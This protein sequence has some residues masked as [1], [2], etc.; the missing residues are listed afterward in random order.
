MVDCWDKEPKS[1]P[2]FQ[3]LAQDL[4][5]AL[6]TQKDDEQYLDVEVRDDS[7]NF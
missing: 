4:R 3:K 7:K 6:E 2:S 5:K 1:R